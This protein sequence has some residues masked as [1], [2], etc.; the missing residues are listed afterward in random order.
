MKLNV[1]MTGNELMAGDIIDSNSAMVADVLEPLGWRIHKKVTVGDDLDLLCN[2]IDQLCDDGDVL[3]IN[4]GL[5]PTVDDLTA[6]AMA[7]V[8]DCPIQEHPD[9]LAHLTA[10]C[11]Q[12]NQSLSKANLKQTQLPAG[13]E[14]IA[15]GRGSAVGIRIEH[16]GCLVLATPGVPSELR[17]MLSE[18]IVPLLHQ[19]FV[20]DHIRTL[21]LGVFGLGESNVQEHLSEAIPNWPVDIEL[22]FRASMPVLEVKLTARGEHLDD[23]LARCRQQVEDALS[24]HIVG[25]LPASLPG[26]L[27]DACRQHQ[28]SV[29]TAESCTGGLIASQL[30]SVAGASDVFPGGIVS[31][32]N[33]IKRDILGVA[34]SDL[35][36]AGAV[37]ETV[38]RQML[39]GALRICGADIGVAVT[40]IAGPGGGSADKPVG[41]VWMAW[42]SR[43]NMHSQRLVFPFERAAFQQW[44]SAL[45]LDLLRRHV[46]GV[47]EI[48]QLMQRFCQGSSGD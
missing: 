21:R 10:W 8:C 27:I 29:C 11:E 22:G 6:E 12:R 26:A 7:R 20:S 18:E 19:R 41:T 43:D 17:Q 16:R 30:T 13:C 38:A 32:S 31:Y 37:S 15:N 14:I 40:G 48:P 33:A 25:E 47:S 2:E 36:R 4:G 42:G 3:L 34:E 9:A 39:S 24:H 35:E 46:A 44:V 45:A 1:L 5:G 28:L 23:A